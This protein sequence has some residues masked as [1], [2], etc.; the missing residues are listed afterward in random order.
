MDKSCFKII[1]FFLLIIGLLTYLFFLKMNEANN[2]KVQ[3]GILQKSEADQSYLLEN[4]SIISKLQHYAEGSHLEN[5]T[6]YTT[7][8]DSCKLQDLCCSKKLVYYFSEQGCKS[9]YLPFLKKLNDLSD[10]LGKDNVVIICK[11]TKKRAFHLFIQD[12]DFKLTPNVYWSKC[13]LKIF[14]EYNDYALAFWLSSDLIIDN[15]CITD[16]SNVEL[17]SDYLKIIENINSCTYEN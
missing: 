11:F 9:C 10:M 5:Y 14:P 1:P 17:S 12:L 13:D 6:L 4:I 7:T 2:Y 16:K 3:I 15:V 8:D